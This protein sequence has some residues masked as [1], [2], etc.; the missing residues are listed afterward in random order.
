MDPAARPR[1]STI[2][3]EEGGSSLL[4]QH[5]LHDRNADQDHDDDDD[6]DSVDEQEQ[7]HVFNDSPDQVGHAKAGASATGIQ[8]TPALDVSDEPEQ[9]DQTEKTSSGTRA[10]MPSVLVASD[11]GLEQIGPAAA[12]SSGTGAQMPFIFN[13]PNDALEQKG[14]AKASSSGPRAQT[15]SAL[16]AANHGPEQDGHAEAAGLDGTA[17][18]LQPPFGEMEAKIA[19]DEVAT[20][21]RQLRPRNWLGHGAIFLILRLLVSPSKAR[22]L[23]VPQP[24]G[25]HWQ[26]C[27]RQ[28]QLQH[29]PPASIRHFLAPILDQGR[30]HWFLL[31]LDASI[32]EVSVLDSLHS[33]EQDLQLSVAKH[34]VKAVGKN[35]E[36]DGWKLT[37]LHGPQQDDGDDCGV[38][39][40]VSCLNIISNIALPSNYN[41]LLWRLLFIL[42]LE[43]GASEMDADEK[44]AALIL[45]ADPADLSDVIAKHEA[46]LRRLGAIGTVMKQADHAS[47][48]ATIIASQIHEEIRATTKSV[49]AAKLSVETKQQLV[50]IQERALQ[51]GLQ[52][53]VDT[54]LL[55]TLRDLL[56]KATKELEQAQGSYSETKLQDQVAQ[57]LY[58]ATSRVQD[59]ICHHK[60][61]AQE[62]LGAQ[63]RVL[64]RIE[65][66][67]KKNREKAAAC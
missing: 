42:A 50:S 62:D 4:S 18:N 60:S 30:K 15:P 57:R 26:D 56:T 16:D 46:S 59:F 20:A 14:C 2:M 58:K 61:S 66:Y 29:P 45:I 54:K 53:E 67:N 12:S 8:I 1:L 52:D 63:Q 31:H 64:D 49:S 47:A 28:F 38:Y 48:V 51:Q 9:Q 32:C 19:K 22:I 21:S 10:Q 37:R 6:D 33:G 44:F 25:S 5:D 39:V 7:S 23:E 17:V 27:V 24:T 40:V 55:S 41:G 34:M 3:E 11:H 35:W 43:D 36:V 65:E 13:A